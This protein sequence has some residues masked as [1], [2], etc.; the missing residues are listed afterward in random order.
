MLKQKQALRE[1]ADS[2]SSDAVRILVIG[3]GGRV[4]G[5]IMEHFAALGHEMIGWARADANLADGEVLRGLLE[6]Q[7]Y[8]LLINPAAMTSVDACESAEEESHA[9]NALAPEVMAQVSLAK[10]ARFFH[11]STDYVFDGH[12]DGARH[13]TDPVN[14]LG[15]YGRTKAEGEQRVLSVSDRFLVI[16]TSWVFGPHR[17]SFLDSILQRARENEVVEAIDDKFS[18]PCYSMD[19]AELL[20]P[21]V[22]EDLGHGLLHLCNSGACSW[23]EYG[24]WALDV[25]GEL[26]FPLKARQVGGIS[27]AEMEHFAAPRPVHTSMCTDRYTGLTGRSPRSW[28]EAVRSYLESGRAKL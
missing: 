25:A 9:V 4:G 11:V 16:R 17:P 10:G 6:R 26:G 3:A 19:F 28:Q 12:D 8:D 5:A 22:A 23:R 13:E 7:D 14:P 20:E 27:L 15:V 2:C 24:Q 21:L 1:G 18:S